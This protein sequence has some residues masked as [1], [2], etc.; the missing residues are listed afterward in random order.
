MIWTVAIRAG[1]VALLT[2]VAVA[3][4]A[5]GADSQAPRLQHD[6]TAADVDAWLDGYL[7][8]VLAQADI[9]GAVVVIVKDGQILT[10]RG[11]G[12]ADLAARQRVNPATTMFRPGSISKLFT[13]TVPL[14]VQ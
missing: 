9:A 5:L 2:F 11:Y 12:Y 7:P 14:K 3:G 13:W 4:M 10:Q 8:Y 1:A 6:L